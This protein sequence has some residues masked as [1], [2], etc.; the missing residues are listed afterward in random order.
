MDRT[1]RSRFTLVA[2]SLGF[3]V[4]QLDV[5]VVNVAIRPIGDALGG[6]VAAL[7]WIVN[8][9][10]IAFAAFILSAGALGDRVGARRVACARE[11]KRLASG[12]FHVA[13]G[14]GPYAWLETRGRPLAEELATRRIFVAPGSAWGDDAHVRVTLR[15]AAATERLLEAL[16]D[17]AH[18]SD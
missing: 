9:Y 11:R 7:Q 3:A 4:V 18:A 16:E 5:S 2:M 1:E 15:D 10:T 8:A 13:P 17:I 14:V 12:P 6:G